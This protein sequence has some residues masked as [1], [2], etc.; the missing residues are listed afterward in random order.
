VSGTHRMQ[1]GGGLDAPAPRARSPRNAL[2]LSSCLT[3]GA[4]AL[5]PANAFPTHD[6]AAR[7]VVVL[8]EPRPIEVAA[9]LRAPP[10][11]APS[12]VAPVPVAPRLLP[13]ARLAA[14]TVEP[15]REAVPP[16]LAVAPTPPKPA[17][18]VPP[19]AARSL[20]SALQ[21]ARKVDIAQVT[22]T[23]PQPLHVPQL[24]EP[25]LAAGTAG[26]LVAKVDAMQVPLPAAPRLT[27][28]ERAVL[29]AEA[30]AEMTVRAGADAVGT[31]AF[32]MTEAGTIDVQLSGLLDLVADRMAPEEYTRLRGAAAADSY[33]PL[34]QLRAV[35]LSLRYDPVY[36]ELDLSA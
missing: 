36:D 32:R 4:L 3:L 34:D 19:V 7:A 10:G 13:G 22:D 5:L 29:L 2:R 6:P 35:G 16:V 25:G 33:V 8:A 26:T 11:L 20:A 9:G 30:P 1:V 18:V 17:F 28:E 15:V 23:A 12:E 14:P 21:P 27:G 24:R 31:V